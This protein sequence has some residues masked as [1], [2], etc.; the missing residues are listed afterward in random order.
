MTARAFGDCRAGRNRIGGRTLTCPQDRVELGGE[1]IHGGS[2]SIFR[3][4]RDLGLTA[5]PVDRYGQMKWRRY[6][7][8]YTEIPQ[9]CDLKKKYQA[10]ISGD[11]RIVSE[12]LLQSFRSCRDTN[13][14]P[15]SNHSLDPLFAQTWCSDIS[16]LSTRDI[17]DENAVDVAGSDEYRIDEGYSAL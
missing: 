16:L 1:F 5:I 8:P 2:S 4:T 9:I 14:I 15:L 10:L 13:D 17:Q 3:L 6:D 7:C 11:F 12:S